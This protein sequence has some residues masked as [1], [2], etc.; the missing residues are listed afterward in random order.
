MRELRWVSSWDGLTSLIS[1]SILIYVPVD[2]LECGGGVV[3]YCGLGV[4]EGNEKEEH[5]AC[6]E[7]DSAIEPG[8]L[9]AGRAG[10]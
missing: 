8:C 1:I 6:D 7:G 4:P 10:A 2:A 9:H 3:C 5:D